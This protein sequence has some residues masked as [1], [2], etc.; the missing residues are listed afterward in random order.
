MADGLFLYENKNMNKN[1]SI[2]DPSKPEVYPYANVLLTPD[3]KQTSRKMTG[4]FE[5]CGAI[6]EFYPYK[7]RA[8]GIFATTVF[9][10]KVHYTDTFRE[11]LGRVTHV[12]YVRNRFLTLAKR[13]LKRFSYN[14]PE[15]DLVCCTGN[16]RYAFIIT[17]STVVDYLSD[18]VSEYKTCEQ[19]IIVT[20]ENIEEVFGYETM[21]QLLYT[22]K[23]VVGTQCYYKRNHLYLKVVG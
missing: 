15:F 11:S 19:W 23:T 10:N 16:L 18:N 21:D 3:M 22:W 13:M 2:Y 17:Y 4:L 20:G 9:G 14:L 6:G 7:D 1:V 8:G 5:Y 12:E